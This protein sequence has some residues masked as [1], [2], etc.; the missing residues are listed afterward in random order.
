MCDSS[1]SG[2]PSVMCEDSTVCPWSYVCRTVA[3]AERISSVKCPPDVFRERV[4]TLMSINRSSEL[5]QLVN[6]SVHVSVGEG[7]T[8]LFVLYDDFTSSLKSLQHKHFHP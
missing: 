4:L 7:Q 5:Q 3:P 2:L 6:N 1:F 8:L